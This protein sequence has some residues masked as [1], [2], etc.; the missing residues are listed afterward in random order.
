VVVATELATNAVLHARSDFV[1]ALRASVDGLHISV[2]D[3]ST[4][5]P[6][7]R[8]DGSEGFSGRGLVLVDAMSALWGTAPTARGKAVWAELRDEAG[9]A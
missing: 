1:V 6:V 3:R 2:E 8:N 4:A 5:A 7:L 9:T